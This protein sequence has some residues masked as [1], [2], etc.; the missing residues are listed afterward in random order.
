MQKVSVTTTELEWTAHSLPFPLRTHIF[1]QWSSDPDSCPPFPWPVHRI[2]RTD[3]Q[4]G[5]FKKPFIDICFGLVG[6][7][8]YTEQPEWQK[9]D[10]VFLCARLQRWQN[11]YYIILQ[12]KILICTEE[13][14]EPKNYFQWLAK[15]CCISLF[16]FLIIVFNT[17]Y[18]FCWQKMPKINFVRKHI[19][20]H[21][22]SPWH[23]QRLFWPWS[24]TRLL[25]LL[26]PQH[27]APASSYL[28]YCGHRHSSLRSHTNWKPVS[29]PFSPCCDG[30]RTD[31]S[32][33]HHLQRFLLTAII[34]SW[35]SAAAKMKFFKQSLP[36]PNQQ[37]NTAFRGMLASTASARLEN[38]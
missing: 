22:R 16:F 23:D 26:C 27:T 15:Y 29:V 1:R 14:F 28:G 31:I 30:W 17:T 36:K 3:M 12:Y 7:F 13:A 9:L 11:V 2:P 34:R 10:N 6:K 8:I 37:T 5:L 18:A 24:T 25:N 32:H 4:D 33:R 20:V 38:T 35:K 21:T 19:K